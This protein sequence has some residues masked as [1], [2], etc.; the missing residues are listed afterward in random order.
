MDDHNVQLGEIASEASLE[1]NAF[2]GDAARQ[3][4]RFLKRQQDRIHEVGGMVL[5]DEDPDYLSVAPDGSFRSRTRYQD[6]KTGEWVS[7]TEVIESPSE[8]IE[9]YNPA[10]IYAAFAE[11]AR[12]AAGFAPEPTAA[13]GLAE[14][15]GLAPEE[16]IGV[17]EDPYA[18]VADTWAKG[19]AGSEE[20]ED[21]PESVD[22]AAE[23]LYDLALSFQER[24]QHQEAHLLEQFQDAAEPLARH[25]GELLIIDDDD[26]RLTLASSGQLKAEVVPEDEE[27]RW[28]SL[29]SPEELVQFYDPTD[30]FG[31]IA[32]SIAE[33][34]P[35]VAAEEGAG[36]GAH[37]EAGAHDGEP[38]DE[39]DEDDGDDADEGEDGDDEAKGDDSD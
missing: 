2:L 24:S 5:I 10:E 7:E 21:E 9:L 16:R 11:A 38:G 13:E 33:A 18:E 4:E 6:E 34:Y 17:P 28:R 36:G 32:E 12:E 39:D 29:A 19:R 30:V 14:A 27:G 31:D 20:P 23:R 25:L 15:A 22:E 8:L 26:E 3:L 37:G 1:R 35:N